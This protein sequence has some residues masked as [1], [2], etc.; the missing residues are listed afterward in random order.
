MTLGPWGTFG[1]SRVRPWGRSLRSCQVKCT[2]VVKG[3]WSP[4][5]GL[6]LVI[7]P[8]LAQFL[9]YRG[10]PY[11]NGKRRVRPRCTPSFIKIAQTVF[12]L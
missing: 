5:G 12:E 10:V 2:S 3:T 8:W 11:Q 9:S 7:G 1:I 6:P 4:K